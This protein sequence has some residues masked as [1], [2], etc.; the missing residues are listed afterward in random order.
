M[1]MH[2]LHRPAGQGKV[3]VSDGHNRDAFRTGN[4]GDA[5]AVQA[6]ARLAVTDNVTF[7]TRLNHQR[8]LQREGANDWL[9]AGGVTVNF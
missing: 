5:L 9:L 7:S 1:D 6:E 4:G 8:R 2:W 3:T